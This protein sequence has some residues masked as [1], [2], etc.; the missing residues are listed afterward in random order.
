MYPGKF[1]SLANKGW[2]WA[3]LLK[4]VGFWVKKKEWGIHVKKKERITRKSCKN[5]G[6]NKVKIKRSKFQ[7]IQKSWRYQR[8]IQV[9]EFKEIKDQIIKKVKN[10][11]NFIVVSK[12]L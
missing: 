12:K 4:H 2:D 10:S 9:G 1:L 3:P 11:K 6:A 5:F 7:K 8:S